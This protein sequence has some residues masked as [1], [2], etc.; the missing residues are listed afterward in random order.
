MTDSSYT[1]ENVF[2]H[3]GQTYRAPWCYVTVSRDVSPTAR[4]A[5]EAWIARTLSPHGLDQF[6]R[7]RHESSL[8]ACAWVDNGTLRIDELDQGL[9]FC[10][11]LNRGADACREWRRQQ[12]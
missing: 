8:L 3:R 5:A 11:L 6:R 10:A 7:E 12:A 4:G 2:E 1:V 9:E